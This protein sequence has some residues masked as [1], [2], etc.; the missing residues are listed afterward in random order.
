MNLK[1]N[2]ISDMVTRLSIQG[3]AINAIG[4]EDVRISKTLYTI[5]KTKRPESGKIGPKDPGDYIGGNY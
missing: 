1:F 4:D 5:K 3:S 2:Q